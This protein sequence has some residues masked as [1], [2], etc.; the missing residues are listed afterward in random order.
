MWLRPALRVDAVMPRCWDCTQNDP[1]YCFGIT[2]LETKPNSIKRLQAAGWLVSFR[3]PTVSW[4]LP[5]EVISQNLHITIM[6]MTCGC[7]TW[8]V[9][10]GLTQIFKMIFFKK[11]KKK[12]GRRAT[13][14]SSNTKSSSIRSPADAHSVSLPNR[15]SAIIV[16]IWLISSPLFWGNLR[17]VIKKKGEKKTTDKKNNTKWWLWH[18]VAVFG[19]RQS[20]S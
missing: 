17:R 7:G 11:K 13:T 10:V 8:T 18:R 16:S 6:E 9:V 20:L 3:L 19:K 12:W 14:Q 4:S 15:L 1:V 2:D 5:T